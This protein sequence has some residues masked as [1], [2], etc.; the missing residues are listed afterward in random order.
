MLGQCLREA[1]AMN[2]V[3]SL[4]DDSERFTLG[5]NDRGLN[6]TLASSK[7]EATSHDYSL[8][9]YFWRALGVIRV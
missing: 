5:Y 4:R 9:R 3:M 2:R 6:Q 1:R 7:A 8:N